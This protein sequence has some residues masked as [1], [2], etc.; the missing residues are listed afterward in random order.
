MDARCNEIVRGFNADRPAR[1]EVRLDREEPETGGQGWTLGFGG[2]RAWNECPGR[3]GD[4]LE[5]EDLIEMLNTAQ[6]ELIEHDFNESCQSSGTTQLA[7][8]TLRLMGGTVR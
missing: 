3:W 2:V 7:P 5:V 1:Y 4:H 8:W 6:Y